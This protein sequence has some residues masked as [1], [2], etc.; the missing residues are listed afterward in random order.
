MK[1]YILAKIVEFGLPMKK[2]HYDFKVQDT[3][4]PTKFIK[5]IIHH[6]GKNKTIQSLID[7]H[8]KKQHYSSIGYH[9]MIS[10]KGTI[11]YARDLK[12][13]GAHTYGYNKNAIGIALFGNFDEVEPTQKQIDA[14]NSLVTKLKENYNIKKIFGH[15]EA[16]YKKIKERNWKLHLPN[17]NPLDIENK[18]TY[19]NFTRDITTQVLEFDASDSSVTLIK[20]FQ[21]CPGFNLYSEIKKLDGLDP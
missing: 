19:K 18:E 3:N 12:S 11:Y 17:I 2:I 5:I 13:A 15:N 7:N 14:L 16:I 20:K 1:Q 8:V 10:K 4:E 9:F 21:S 6:T